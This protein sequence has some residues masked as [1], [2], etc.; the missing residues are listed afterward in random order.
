[1]PRASRQG[2]DMGR[3]T[4]FTLVHHHPLQLSNGMKLDNLIESPMPLVTQ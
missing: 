4:T 1:M 2:L 3:K